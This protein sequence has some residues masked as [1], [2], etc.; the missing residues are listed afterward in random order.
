MFNMFKHIIRNPNK[1][2]NQNIIKNYN[3]YNL[4]KHSLCNLALDNNHF[5][6]DNYDNNEDLFIEK[7][8]YDNKKKYFSITKQP[9]YLDK[10]YIKENYF[11]KL[12][13]IKKIEL[14]CES[15]GNKCFN[16]HGSGYTFNGLSYDLC[17]L[18]NGNGMY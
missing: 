13:K 14:I 16:C 17:I 11:K 15:T 12:K 4:F 7:V 6:Y 5:N 8:K 10:D 18:C 2:L 1:N 9:Y 3:K